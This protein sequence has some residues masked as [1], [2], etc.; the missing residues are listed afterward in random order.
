MVA[1][2]N[3]QAEQ[4]GPGWLSTLGGAAL[5][6]VV[7][8]GVGMLAGTAWEEPDLVM[9]HLAG[10]TTE[11]PL[12][13]ELPLAAEVSA[14]PP[15]APEPEPAARP[16]GARGSSSDVSK[17]KAPVDPPSVSAAPPLR[18]SE[19]PPARGSAASATRRPAP[20]ITDGFSIQVGAFGEK[21]TATRLARELRAGG[22]SVHVHTDDGPGGVR[23]RVRVGPVP[24]R[25]EATRL[26]GKLESNHQLPTWILSPD[27]P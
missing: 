20:A 15:K 27:S 17:T 18:G 14:G 3:R 16:L 5:L 13:S 1:K 23:Y 9:D 21:G 12:A 7:G 4:A 6:L 2:R 11:L 26:A 22:F 10:R 8:F 25:E 24:T 19:P